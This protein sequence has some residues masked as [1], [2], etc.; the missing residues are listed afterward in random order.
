MLAY[1]GGLDTSVAI[2]WLQEELGYD[3]ITLTAD[4]GE[5]K[6]V[7]A[8]ATRALRTGALSAHVADARR[9]FVDAFCFP[10]LAAGALY[11][12][13]YPL[14]TALARPLIAKLLVDVARE[15]GA[16]AVAHGCTGKGNDQ[17]RFDVAVGA[18]APELRVVAPVRDWDMGRPDEF[19]VRGAA[20][21]R[22]PGHH[23]I[24]VLDRRQPLGPQHRDRRARGSV[25][26]TPRRRVRSGRRHDHAPGVVVEIGFER[27]VPVSLDGRRLEGDLL[28]AEL[29]AT[30]GARG[31]GR[32]D[33]VENRLVGIKSREIYEAPA[34][35]TLH[36]AH[37]ALESLTITRDV[38]RF[39]RIVADEWARLVYDGLWFSALRT[40][41]DA[42]VQ[43]TQV[44]VTGTV[45]MRLQDGVAQVVG[46]RAER[47][48]YSNNLATYDR[49]GDT[50]DHAAARGFIELFGLPLRTQTRVQGALEDTAPLHVERRTQ[51]RGDA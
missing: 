24:A 29:N 49:A 22:G 31:I 39:Q 25:D 16:S 10:T 23:G 30:A 32:I 18:L 50:F 14:A 6:D 45:R 13:V 3:V 37:H 21:H 12:G 43:E 15:E 11:E 34:A 48:L 2:R 20:R 40:A 51:R 41:L 42:F 47:S 9:V 17:V 35:V 1:S 4:L 27:G 28:V 26:R 7:D 38:A 44:H 5:S 8:V 46:R 33:H 19:D 36:A